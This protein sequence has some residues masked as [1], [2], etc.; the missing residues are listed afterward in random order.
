MCILLGAVELDGSISGR[1]LDQL[2]P[3]Q[4]GLPPGFVARNQRERILAA[5]ARATSAH[6]YASMSVA[7]VVE[8]AGVS[9]RTFYEL[10][11]DKDDAFLA[12]Y[13]EAARR[14]LAR[15]RGAAERQTTF[16]AR[17]SAG[18]RELLEVLAASPDFARMCIVEV[19]AAGPAAVAVRTQV[20]GELAEVI[21]ESARSRG[22]SVPAHGL[23][24]ETIVGGIYEGV[25]RRVAK[26]E[27]SDLPEL[28]PDLV[29][30]TLLP[31]LGEEEAAAWGRQ[32]RTDPSPDAP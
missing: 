15:V 17:I 6:G 25:Y 4:H 24:G 31:Y 13:E 22:N 28:L 3:G 1:A 23:V 27:T 2:P 10:F 26:G 9:R 19:L 11:D 7:D 8:E 29:E 12:A 5:V 21:D 30:S 16:P 20:M 14:L 32:L 18:L